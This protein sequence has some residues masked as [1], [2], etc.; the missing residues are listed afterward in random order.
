MVTLLTKPQCVQCD[1]TKRVLTSEGIAFQ[2]RDMIQDP[3]ALKLAKELGYLAAPVVIA[4]DS[5]WSGFQP[6]RI[7]GLALALA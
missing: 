7:K 1:L 4:G 5:H 6:E 3:E 2:E